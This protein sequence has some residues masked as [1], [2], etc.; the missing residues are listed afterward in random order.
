M[1][2]ELNGKLGGD[3]INRIDRL[4]DELTGNFFGIMRYMP[5]NTGL[6]HIFAFVHGDAALEN[7]LHKISGNEFSFEFWKRHSKCE[8]DAYMEINDVCIGIE[9]KY[10]SGKSGESQL[11]REAEALADWACNRPAILLFIAP[12][13]TA[14]L[15]YEEDKDKACFKK[16]HLGYLCWEDVLPALE[17]IKT[18][19]HYEQIMISDLQDLMRYKGFVAFAGFQLPEMLSIDSNAFYSFSYNLAWPKPTQLIEEGLFYEFS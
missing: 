16:I 12:A 15:V 4:E 7:I 14:K 2:A 1:L 10:G 19:N 6:K 5:Y 13:T 18:E 3:N 9:V 8:I 11:E 17:S